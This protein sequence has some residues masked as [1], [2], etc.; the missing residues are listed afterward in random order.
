MKSIKYL[1]ILIVGLFTACSDGFLDQDLNSNQIIADGYY[2]SDSE[3]ETATTTSYSFI[4]YPDWWQNQW[5]RAVNEAASDNAW[6]G[7]NGGQGTAIQAA[8]YTLNGENDR[9]E[10]HWIMLYKSI[11]R[12]NAT[13]EGVERANIS[14]ALKARCIA[15]IKFLRAFQYVELVRNFGGVP[16][17]TQTLG[18]TEN[19]YKRSS[20]TEIYDF[21]AKDLMSAIPDLP[22]KSAYTSANKFRVSKGAATALL[23]KIYL[24]AEKWAEASSAAD[25]VIA[26]NEYSLEPFFGDV[27]RTSNYNGRE[28][29]FEIQYQWS[30]LFPALGNIFPITSMSL[31]EGGWGYF[32]PSSDLENAFKSQ[33]DSTRLNWTIMRHGFPVVGEVGTPIFN[34]RPDRSKSARFGRKI[35]ALKAERTPNNKVSKNKIHIRFAEVLLIKAEA[36]AMLKQDAAALA[37]LKLVRERVGLKVD[38]TLTGDKLINAVRLE[39]RLE[40][41]MEGERLF[42]IRRWKDSGGTPVINSIFGPNGSFV[43]YNTTISTD[44]FETKN[45]SEPQNK[46]FNFVAGKHNLWPIPTK[47]VDASGGLVEQNAGY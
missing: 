20:P 15:E 14:Q 23:A 45:L 5:L 21:L 41:A 27:F 38:N 19:T 28:S 30:T 39:R 16:F 46:G 42:D 10:A 11:D 9:I 34:G 40:M 3:V 4:D 17:L 47:E 22:A 1:L 37:A 35:Y 8:H 44:P 6:I 26:S 12:F 36:A 29:I 18:V 13:L 25:Q 32:S 7:L 31:A 24:Y 2:N 33:G 43:V